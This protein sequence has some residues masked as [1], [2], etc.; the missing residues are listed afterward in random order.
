MD[1]LKE[2]LNQLFA[3]AGETPEVLYAKAELLQMMED[4]YEALLEEGKTE[5]EA[6]DIIIAEFGNF[7]EISKELGIDDVI[8]KNNIPTNN[9]SVMTDAKG[10]ERTILRMTKDQILNYTKFAKKHAGLVAGGIAAF[11]LAPFFASI[12]DDLFEGFIGHAAAGALSGLAFFLFI[13]IGV[14]SMIIAANLTKRSGRL[15]KHA[16]TLDAD[17]IEDLDAYANKV[18]SRQVIMLVIGI[19]FCILAPAASALGDLMVGPLGIIF[20]SGVL[21]FAAIGVFFIVYSSSI[22]NRLEELDKGVKHYNSVGFA[23]LGGMAAAGNN[24]GSATG[25]A[26]TENVATWN[27]EP[28]SHVPVWVIIVVIVFSSITLG[29]VFTCVP[30]FSGYHENFFAGGQQFDGNEKFPASQVNNIKFDIASSNVNLNKGS[31]SDITIAYHGSF[32]KQPKISLENGELK[33]K[34]ND[35][36]FHL[37]GAGNTSGTIDIN[38]PET[39]ISDYKFDMA[40][41]NLNINEIKM[42]SLDADLAAGDF[43][44]NNGAIANRAKFEMAAGNLTINGTEVNDL[45]AE[46]AAGNFEYHF[47]DKNDADNFRFDLNC[48]L[49]EL[50]FFGATHGGIVSQ[51]AKNGGGSKS[52]KVEAAAGR[53]NVD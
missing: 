46:L 34:V 33:V 51:S 2:Y 52:M 15:N 38:I 12:C 23:P 31:G 40:A 11:I 29:T 26:P 36:K 45:D 48:A 8:D 4:K 37:F 28:K 35:S 16:I 18:N 21:L 25:S 1:R 10:K 27:Y 43:V 42:N 17:A 5:D 13:A 20:D 47:K 7:E 3:G 24:V 44:F 6:V 49:G 50:N 9:G 32:V 14:S 53:I 30:F 19:A 22:K 39:C 41:G